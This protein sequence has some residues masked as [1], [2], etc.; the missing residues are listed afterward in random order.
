M[1]YMETIGTRLR[2]AR[3]EAKL[4]QR[5]LGERCG[6]SKQAISNIERGDTKELQGSTLDGAC[7]ALGLSSRWL[8]TGRGPKF[9]SPSQS[10]TLD[11]ATLVRTYSTIMEVLREDG[12]YFDMDRHAEAFALVYKE[13]G[14]LA[15][16]DR[17]HL[18]DMLRLRPPGSVTS[19]GQGPGSAGEKSGSR[20]GRAAG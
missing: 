17:A 6:V 16:E 8:L 7:R 15:D 3:A 5:E 19:E 14:E 18:R 13:G 12:R 1:V 2:A 20:S 9:A 10:V 11:P 4:T